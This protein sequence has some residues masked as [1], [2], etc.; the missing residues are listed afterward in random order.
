M[1]TVIA[2]ARRRRPVSRGF[3]RQTVAAAGLMERSTVPAVGL[4]LYW[5]FYVVCA[6]GRLPLPRLDVE[7]EHGEHG[8]ARVLDLGHLEPVEL[9]RVGHVHP[10]LKRAREPERVEEL[11]SRVALLPRG[12]GE[13]VGRPRPRGGPLHRLR[14]RVEEVDPPLALHPPHQQKLRPKQRPEREWGHGPRGGP[15]LKPRDPAPRLPH[16]DAH[17]RGHRPPPVD[18]LRLA[19][20]LEER[21][22]APEPQRVETVVPRQPPSSHSGSMKLPPPLTAGI[23]DFLGAT[24]A[25]TMS[26]LGAAGRAEAGAESSD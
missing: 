4:T 25:A 1:N 17:H 23:Q 2:R 19:V 5:A 11:A 9:V 6:E 7:D 8:E 20:P 3:W 14:L 12:I 18:E 15:R 13:V 21:R 22:V 26:R 16:E 10:A 24:A